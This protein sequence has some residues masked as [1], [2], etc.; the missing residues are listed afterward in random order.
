MIPSLI[1]ASARQAGLDIIAITDHNSCENAGSVMEAA[2]CSGV[3]VLPGLEVQSVEGVHLLCLFDSLDEAMRL[4]EAVY[5]SL[6]NVAG[7]RKTVEQQFIV[8]ARDEFIAFCE[9]P[10]WLPTSMDVDEVFERVGQLNG[11]LIPSHIDRLGTGMCGVL[12]ML[13][14]TPVFDA[15]E[16]SANLSVTEARGI[17]P[18]IAGRP[19]LQNSDSHWLSAIGQRRTVLH[20]EHRSIEEIRRACRGEGGRRVG[21]A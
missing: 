12:G 14:E 17:Y 3:R 5:A 20:L 6:P 21:N 18:S 19:V 16:V 13:P 10:I 2:E 8:D 11:I 4:Q 7:A 15:V 9:R 1:V